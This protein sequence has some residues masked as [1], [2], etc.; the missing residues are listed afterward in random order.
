MQSLIQRY[1][2]PKDFYQRTAR[3]AIPL[4]LQQLLS[5]A[6]GIVDTLMVSWIGMVTA[7]GTAAQIDTLCSM[8][9]YGS[10]GGTGMFSSQF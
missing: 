9:A 8:I 10:I 6:M 4:A 7:V 1:F 3:V 5:S 2:G